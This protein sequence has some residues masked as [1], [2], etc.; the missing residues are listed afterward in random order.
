MTISP[1][2]AKSDPPFVPVRPTRYWEDVQVGEKTESR[3]LKV[4]HAN[5]VEFARKYDPQYFHTDDTMAQDTLFGGLIG[6]GIY[7]AAL[8]RILD[9]ECN[10]DISFVCGIAWDNVKWNRPLRAGDVIRAKSEVI[11]KRLSES[12]PGIG[13]AVLRHELVKEDGTI[14]LSFDSVDLIYRRPEQT[15]G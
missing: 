2:S 5:M 8:W 7:S 13:I 6:S 14:V 15:H 11:S 9:H 10:G 12:K 1:A 3:A 4:E